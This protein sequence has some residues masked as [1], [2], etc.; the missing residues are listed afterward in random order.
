MKHVEHTY[1]VER[2]ASYHSKERNFNLKVYIKDDSETVNVGLISFGIG[3]T[4]VAQVALSELMDSKRVRKVVILWASRFGQDAECFY[5]KSD[6]VRLLSEGACISEKTAQDCDVVEYFLSRASSG[7][8]GDRLSIVHI[9][10]QEPD[11]KECFGDTCLHG[12]IDDNVLKEVFREFICDRDEKQIDTKFL[13]V[14]T[15]EM[16]DQAYDRLARLG[17]DTKSDETGK[18][19]LLLKASSRTASSDRIPSPLATIGESAGDSSKK[20]VASP[21]VEH[22]EKRLRVE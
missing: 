3:I 22:E 14:G 8:F 9:F 2:Q 19:R 12:R 16:M 17:F 4:E 5:P 10:S 7:V 20:R 1:W 18:H 11:K 21:M 15:A 13:S 6:S